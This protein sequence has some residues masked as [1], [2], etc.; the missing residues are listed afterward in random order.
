MTIAL[1]APDLGSLRFLHLQDRAA[2]LDFKSGERDIDRNI[3]KCYERHERHRTRIFCA[4]VDGVPQAYWFYCLS[5]SA[6][7][8]SGMDEDIVR[9]NDNRSYV[10]FIY[11]DYFAVRHE[12]QNRKI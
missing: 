5:V 4:H 2:F 9:A 3:E 6:S 1:R 10:P 8:A 7:T 11:V 12:F